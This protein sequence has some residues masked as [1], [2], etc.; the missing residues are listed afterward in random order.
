VRKFFGYVRVSTA[1]QGEQGV[2]LQEQREAIER[3]AG[4]NELEIIQWFEERETAAK[5]GRPIFTQMLKLLRKGKADGVIIHKIDRSARNLKDWADLGELIDQGIEV[6][7]ANESL[8]L[9]SRGGRL[10]AD[11][12]AVVA[13]DF[14]RNL[15]EETRK[16]FYGRL[17]QGLYPMCA[18]IGY[19]DMGGGKP[20]EPHP[21]YGPLVRK[22]FE[23]YATG[24]YG[25]ERLGKEMTRLGLKNR[26]GRPF[27]LNGFSTIL[28]N[29]FYMG[30]IRI[31]KTGEL[32]AGA[33]LPLITKSLFDRVQT[34]LKGRVSTRAP[35]HCFSFRR[36]IVCAHCSRS[37]IGE[38]HKGYVYYRCQ[39]K[40]C[41][42]TCVREHVI[43]ERAKHVLRPLVLRPEEKNYLA[44]KLPALLKQD[45]GQRGAALAAIDLQ[46]AQSKDR[47]IRLTDAYVDRLIERE[48][49]E[50]RKRALL[51]TQKDLEE[52]RAQLTNARTSEASRLTEILELAESAYFLYEMT[53]PEEKPDFLRILTSNRTATAKN[54]EFTL[55]PP[56]REIAKRETFTS[57]GPYRGVPRTWDKILQYY[58]DW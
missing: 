35:R 51:L 27:S 12:Q 4:R 52:R 25:L 58:I 5:R 34:I 46:I 6:Q 49:F 11:I 39:T 10:S 55:Y 38:T 43:E 15:R 29:P 8:D 37:L 7:F 31:E 9:T 28:N 23:L 3:H 13:S 19:R 24:G 41:P 17:K 2:S 33:H 14:I 21:I 45:E 44:S 48:L 16:G 20:K 18:P 42:V 22:A 36:L 54:L 40:T 53:L 57:G 47:L 32:F 30:L 1:K 50:E 26:A 56:F